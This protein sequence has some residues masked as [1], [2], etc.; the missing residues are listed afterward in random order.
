MSGRKAV[1]P[2]PVARSKIQPESVPS[3]AT[4]QDTV[5]APVLGMPETAKAL[6]VLTDILGAAPAS[7]VL[8]VKSEDSDPICE[9]LRRILSRQAPLLIQREIVPGDPRTVEVFDIRDMVFDRNYAGACW[10]FRKDA[11]IPESG[12]DYNSI[13]DRLGQWKKPISVTGA[14]TLESTEEDE[15]ESESEEEG[16]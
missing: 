10:D 15:E 11:S 6:S 5:S 9:A 7:V 3:P 13:L 2:T 8:G 12:E 4:G 16:E 14:Y 1:S